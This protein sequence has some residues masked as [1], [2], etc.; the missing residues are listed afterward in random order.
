MKKRIILAT[1]VTALNALLY[2]LTDQ[3]A[4]AERGYSAFGGEDLLFVFGIAAALYIL[5]CKTKKAA[6]K[7]PPLVKPKA[8][9]A[10]QLLCRNFIVTQKEENVKTKA[11]NYK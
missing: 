11:R 4:T 9:R 8:S 6:V 1:I 2:Q 10:D 3:L 5:F 7:K